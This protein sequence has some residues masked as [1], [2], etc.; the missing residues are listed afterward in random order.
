MLR[1][2]ASLILLPLLLSGCVT[3]GASTPRHFAL[4][5]LEGTRFL[6]MPE[7][8]EVVLRPGAKPIVLGR[9]HYRG[10]F[11]DNRGTYYEAPFSQDK[12]VHFNGPHRGGIYVVRTD[13]G[14][15]FYLYYQQNQVSATYVHGAGMFTTGGDN[16]FTIGDELPVDLLPFLS[17]KNS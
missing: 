9:G 5:R 15:R 14:P 4:T 10:Y 8:R 6:L 1:P 17:D 12:R 11:A 2:C 16:T 13:S 3:P 7:P